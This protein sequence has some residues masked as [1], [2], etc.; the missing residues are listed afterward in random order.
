M[1]S[2]ESIIE[3]IK[4]KSLILPGILIAITFHELAHG[5]SAYLL[6][7]STAKN[8]GRLSLNPLRHIDIVGFIFLLTVGFGWAKPVPINSYNFKNRKLGTIIVS[9]AGPATNFMLAIIGII[10]F[11]LTANSSELIL[12]I[13]YTMIF[14]NVILGVFNLIPLPPLDGSKIIAS[15]LPTK[16][17]FMFYKYE[18]Y[19]Y[20]LLILLMISNGV[21]I[22]LEPVITFTNNIIFKVLYF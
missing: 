10:I 22:I 4:N 11:S 5:Y 3:F 12:R 20:F 17:E 7:D 15:L 9:I 21:E 2:V 8:Q 19:L 16:Y 18:K 6:G 14:Y 1:L 13:V